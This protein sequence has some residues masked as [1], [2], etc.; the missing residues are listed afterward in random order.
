VAPFFNPL[1]ISAKAKFLA[2]V[3]LV[4]APLMIL[5]NSTLAVRS[6]LTLLAWCAISGTIAILWA[7]SYIVS[8]KLLPVAILFNLLAAM[9]MAT[10][11]PAFIAPEASRPSVFGVL[12]A[13]LI[14][15][16]YV[17]FVWFVAGEGARTL[18]L[19][20]EL[21]LARQIHRGLV[22]PLTLS[23]SAVEIY[24]RSD[25]S[26]EMGGDLIDLIASKDGGHID[27]YL[28]DVSGHGVRAGVLMAMV[29]SAL[30]TSL[31]SGSADLA[32]VIGDL[33]RVVAQVKEQDMFVTL[34]AA[35][36]ETRMH[37]SAGSDDVAVR[38]ALAGHLPILVWRRQSRTLEAVDN[39]SFP[40]G[41]ADDESFDPTCIT[42][43]A[44]DLFV[45]YTDG[46]I[47]CTSAA[48]EEFGMARLRELI[49][50][51]ADRAL[52]ELFNVILDAV[53]SHGNQQDDQTI[54][55]ARIR[56]TSPDS[57]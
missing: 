45:L 35:R 40:L 13:L 24:G 54:L 46:L 43:K 16:G 17:F 26:S 19:H 41:V 14:A 21:R 47:E 32:R 56:D 48:G 34:A 10:R 38:C 53:R 20:T 22:P 57:S 30:R 23:A 52:P 29:K 50:A 27:V 3:F 15:G 9:S 39:Q 33:N 37:A 42:C 31:L 7:A 28:A 18:R 12:V 55:L 25:P 2:A 8:R 6:W 4:F 5:T 51:N 1:A 36:F 49:A 11:W 44:G